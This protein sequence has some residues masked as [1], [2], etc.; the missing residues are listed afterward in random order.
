MSKKDTPSQQAENNISEKV[1]GKPKKQKKPVKTARKSPNSLRGVQQRLVK[2]LSTLVALCVIFFIGLY[3]Y[4]MVFGYNL[5]FSLFEKDL[6]SGVQADE[7]ITNIALFGLDTREGDTKSHADCIMIVTVDNVHG[8][9]KLIS[10]M[11]DSLVAIDGHGED[12]INA[13]Y[14]LGGP[15]LAIRTIN[16]NFGTDIQNYVAV[17]FEQMAEMIDILDGVEIDV[18][19]YELEELNRV[20]AD[21]GVEQNKTFHGVEKS[22]FQNLNGVQA[23]CYGRIRKGNT[24][25]DWGRVERQSIVLQEM[26]RKVQQ[27]SANKLLNLMQ[28]LLPHVTT[29][30]T[31]TEI[32]PLIVGALRNGVP[33]LEHTRMPLDGE[34]EYSGASNEYIRF[35]INLIGDHIQKYIYD[36][37]FPGDTTSSHAAGSGDAPAPSGTDNESPNE[38]SSGSSTE[39]DSS[40][41]TDSETDSSGSSGETDEPS[42]TIDPASLAEEGGRYDPETG[43]YYDSDGDRY[44]LNDDGD[45][46]YY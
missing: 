36:D 26:F 15:A 22:G 34:W 24:G 6:A 38:N 42:D 12:K 25:D 18:Q 40:T 23:L 41:G 27:L 1:A 13:A 45:R 39:T 44:F 37:I 8:K 31:P 28:K 7:N 17:N 43:D 11:R 10:L 29:S 3:A 4:H 5:D 2:L 46:V 32:A 16:E 33:K 30:L 19:D 9:I 20:I 35:N 14:F 21:Y